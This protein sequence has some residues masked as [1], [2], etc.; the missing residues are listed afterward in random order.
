MKTEKLGRKLSLGGNL[1][2]RRV[3]Y[4]GDTLGNV[5]LQSINAGLQESLL[6]VI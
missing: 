6:V 4:E 1:L 2:L 3:V 5:A